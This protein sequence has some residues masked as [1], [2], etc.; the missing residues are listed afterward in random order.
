VTVRTSSIEALEA[1]R[2]KPDA[3]DLI[4]TDMTMPNMTGIELAK[5]IMRIHPT[6]PIVLC[7]GFSAQID[8]GKA[9]EIGIRAFVMKPIE[10]STIANAIREALGNNA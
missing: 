10:M 2:N 3:F 5:E 1:F 6:I 4:I 9:K 7:T 8:E